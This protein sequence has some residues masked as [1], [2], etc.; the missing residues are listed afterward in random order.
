MLGLILLLDEDGRHLHTS[1]SVSLPRDYV[2]RHILF[3]S[4]ALGLDPQRQYSES[5][6]NEELRRWTARF[7][8]PVNLDH[9]TLRRSLVDEGYLNRD[10][11]GKSCDLTTEWPYTFDPSIK[12][13]DLE[14]LITEAR[15]ARELEKQQ[16]LIRSAG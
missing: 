2:Q 7:G 15:V 3:I 1:A 10:T 12:T 6:L 14:A 5:E 16:Y 9:V 13:P 11:A 4:A 8:S